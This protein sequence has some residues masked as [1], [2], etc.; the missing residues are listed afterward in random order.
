MIKWEDWYKQLKDVYEAYGWVFADDP[1]AWREYF[2]EGF[3]PRDAFMEAN[4]DS[5]D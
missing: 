3:S 5:P 4:A 2:D 1:E